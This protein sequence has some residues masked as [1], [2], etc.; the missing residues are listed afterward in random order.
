MTTVTVQLP[1]DLAAFVAETLRAG[2]FESADE[3]FARALRLLRSQTPAP[4]GVVEL[5]RA[6]FDGPTFLAGLVGK[7]EQSRKPNKPR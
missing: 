5:T 7:L 1:D 6:G 4:V 3:L 2:T